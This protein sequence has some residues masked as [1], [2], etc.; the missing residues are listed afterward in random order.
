MMQALSGPTTAPGRLVSLTAPDQASISSTDLKYDCINA[1][2]DSVIGIFF[3]ATLSVQN[4]FDIII[5]H[6]VYTIQSI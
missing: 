6:F 5:S 4:L 3:Y 1:I 2:T